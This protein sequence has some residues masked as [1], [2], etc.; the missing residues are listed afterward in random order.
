MLLFE[1]IAPSVLPVRCSRPPTGGFVGGLS[2]ESS[3][4]PLLSVGI[5]GCPEATEGIR[6]SNEGIIGVEAVRR[7]G[8]ISV[9]VGQQEKKVVATLP[10]G[11]MVE[12][13]VSVG[14]QEKAVAM[15]QV[16][17]KV[18]GT[19]LVEAQAKVVVM[20]QE[21]CTGEDLVAVAGVAA[22]ADMRL[23]ENMVEAPGMAVDTVL[24]VGA[25]VRPT[26]MLAGTA[27]VMREGIIATFH[28]DIFEVS[29]RED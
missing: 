24:E 10:V 15:L 26:V 5:P 2:Q 28:D 29:E 17:N 18:E 14:V 1:A 6:C 20:V 12:V 25:A 16:E 4:L 23:G 11:S 22:V 7:A 9:L 3:Y 27:V 8:S 19:V 21:E 13:T